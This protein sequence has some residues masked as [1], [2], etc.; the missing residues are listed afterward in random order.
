MKRTF[1]FTGS[2]DMKKSPYKE[3]QF[4]DPDTNETITLK[5]G[6]THS[7][8]SARLAAE[9]EDREDMEET[10]ASVAR[11]DGTADDARGTKVSPRA[12]AKRS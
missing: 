8:E 3:I 6:E 10:E 7:T 2:P 11:V 4:L 5:K 12:D 9:L 1:K